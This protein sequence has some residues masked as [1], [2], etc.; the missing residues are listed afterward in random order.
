MREV[1]LGHE[2]NRTKEEEKEEKYKYYINLIKYL[3]YKILIT[4]VVEK[5]H[6]A[7]IFVQRPY[8]IRNYH[9]FRA[10]M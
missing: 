1:T 6:L 4:I 9:F 3:L 7:I 5:L 2:Y 8:V 10:S